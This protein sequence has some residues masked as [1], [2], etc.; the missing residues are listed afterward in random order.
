MTAAQAVSLLAAIHAQPQT[1]SGSVAPSTCLPMA[2][3]LAC[4]ADAGV[5]LQAAVAQAAAAAS[6]SSTSGIH[7][8]CRV[9]VPHCDALR[10]SLPLFPTPLPVS[11]QDHL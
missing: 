4:F 2:L 9:S 11:T 5:P 7:V 3:L 1:P 6:E 10:G 8:R